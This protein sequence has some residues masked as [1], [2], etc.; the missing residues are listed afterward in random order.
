MQRVFE[1]GQSLVMDGVC[2]PALVLRVIK[3][4]SLRQTT[5]TGPCR[6]ILLRLP[7]PKQI[8][9]E[10]FNDSV[11]CAVCCI[12]GIWAITVKRGYSVAPPHVI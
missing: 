11:S 7:N 12:T 6:A 5:R 9:E 2:G 10:Q 8:R 4:Q 3:N 1:T